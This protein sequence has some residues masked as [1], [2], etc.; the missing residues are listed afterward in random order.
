MFEAKDP[1]VE[2]VRLGMDGS[3]RRKSDT[4]DSYLKPKFALCSFA[5]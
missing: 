2:K 1:T 4:D 3:F 5:P